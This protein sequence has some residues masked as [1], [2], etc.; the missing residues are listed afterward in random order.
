MDKKT[1]NN[2]EAWSVQGEQQAHEFGQLAGG[3]LEHGGAGG[4]GGAGT[5]ARPLHAGGPPVRAACFPLLFMHLWSAARG[6]GL[7]LVLTQVLRL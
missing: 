1:H 5:A 6:P 4:P 3:E 7:L 2:M